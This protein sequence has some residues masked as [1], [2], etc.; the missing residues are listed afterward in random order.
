MT[1]DSVVIL[2]S[3]LAD[4]ASHFL[5]GLLFIVI[6]FVLSEFVLKLLSI[7]EDEQQLS[8]TGDDFSSLCIRS[9]TYSGLA[10]KIY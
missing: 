2:S 7:L 10:L 8:I 5:I 6:Y 3:S 9:G 4:F 1:L